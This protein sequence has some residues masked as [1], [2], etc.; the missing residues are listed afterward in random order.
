MKKVFLSLS[1]YIL[2]IWGLS[3]QVINTTTI[4]DAEAYI[5]EDSWFL[6]DLDNTLFQAKQALGHT[7]WF[8]HEM[9][10]RISQGMAKDEA[11][12]D[13]NPHWV[14][15]QKICEVI[16]VE[17]HTPAFIQKLQNKGYI[18]MGFTHRPCSVIDSTLRQAQ[19]IGVNF[20]HSSLLQQ[21]VIIP[22]KKDQAMHT[23]G[24][25]FSGSHNSKGEIL[26]ALFQMAG[27]RPKKI[28][29][30]DDKDYNISSLENLLKETDIEY[31][32]IHYRGVDNQPK[33]FH[34]EI[35]KVQFDYMNKII[36]NEMAMSLLQ[37]N[38]TVIP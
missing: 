22:S 27:K 10:E 16:P 19:S 15:S 20:A 32:G 18:V 26:D 14:E 7:D 24:I 35:A 9:K 30:I 17:E 3:A 13:F 28:V 11:I 37:A 29:F 6:V 23:Q 36:S 12:S 8:E 1:L 21:D 25:I 38:E 31:V 5:D 2:S 4:K 34:P 33:I